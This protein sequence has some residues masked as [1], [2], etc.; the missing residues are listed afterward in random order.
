MSVIVSD[1]R[2]AS[3]D[4]GLATANGFFRAEAYNL[5]MNAQTGSALNTFRTLAVTFANAGNCQ[6]IIF[7]MFAISSAL[8]RIVTVRLQ[9]ATAVDSFNTSTERVNRV[10]HGLANDTPV[11][12]SSTG[13]LP[14]GITAGT[15]YY[16]INQ[17]AN[18][19]QISTTVGGSAVGLS[20]TPT[21]TATAW[22]DRAS[23]VMSTTDIMGAQPT[24]GTS[25][26]NWPMFNGFVPIDFATP[27]AVDTTANK[28]R[29][30]IYQSGGTGGTWYI[31]TS[32][33]TNPFYVTWCDT[34]I[35]SAD[36]DVL[37]VKDKVIFNKSITLVGLTGTG[38]TTQST[39]GLICRNSDF[40]PANVALLEWENPPSS[41]YTFTLKGDFYCFGSHSGFRIGTSGSPI[42]ASTPFT[43][44]LEAPTNGSAVRSTL[45]APGGAMSAS[46]YAAKGSFFAYGE[47]PTLRKTQLTSDALT[48]QAHL[49]VADDVSSW[50]AGDILAVGKQDTASGGSTADLVIQSVA[51][52][53]ITLTANLLTAA[54]LT[55]GSVVNLTR[56]YGGY[57]S[58]P[59]NLLYGEIIP[60]YPSNFVIKGCSL[61]DVRVNTSSRTYYYCIDDDANVSGHVISD[62]A[63]R[64]TNTTLG[65][66][67][68]AI[69]AP[70]QEIEISRNH[71]FRAAIVNAITGYFNS[72]LKT[73]YAT[74]DDNI[75]IGN[76]TSSNFAPSTQ[77]KLTAR[78]NRFE[79]SGRYG[80][81]IGGLDLIFTD[82]VFWG[83][84]AT[85]AS[86][87]STLAVTQTFNPIEVGRNT[88]DKCGTAWQ[89]NAYVSTGC[90]DVDSVFGAEAANIVDIKMLAGS[91]IDYTF[92]SP[93]G[94]LVID[95]TYMPDAVSGSELRFVD[96]ND[97][98]HSDR[99]ITP[100]GTFRRCGYG[101]TDTTVWNGSAFAAADTPGQYAMRMIPD[102]NAAGILSYG[103]TKTTGDISGKLMNVSARVK[104]KNAA[105]YAGTHTNPT[106]RVVYDTT[107][108]IS[109]VAANTTDAQLLQVTFTPQTSAGSIRVYVE[110]GTDAAE[111]DAEFYLGELNIPLPEGVS[112]DTTRLGIWANALPLPSSSTFES[113]DSAWSAPSSA[114][115][116]PGT[117][118]ALLK[119]LLT[120]GQFIGLK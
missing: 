88:F 18:D 31:L 42:P 117:M 6:G 59:S 4:Q 58:A 44:S 96:F 113:P 99:T 79:N 76:Q 105:Y 82:N 109:S 39:A 66:F 72:N 28:W 32:D 112:V 10:A 11:T 19:Y 92:Q 9:E 94:S 23:N 110:G 89:H 13:T 57:F 52:N 47:I 36:N 103:Q 24:S 69:Y 46:T 107:E 65:A 34:Q 25:R 2:N 29:F 35:T 8:D 120:I 12:F 37:I 1:S 22:A 91:I 49:I 61:V 98:T 104:I 118:G 43:I 106:L 16:V 73:G 26:N 53:D 63:C 20:G 84:T 3:Y 86:D 67:V 55:G 45:R 93:S 116:T 30:H 111:A 41:A 95:T 56:G 48:G 33:G 21:G 62:N 83:I 80:A 64:M 100:E 27:Y 87:Y 5:G 71:L 7:N 15:V 77:A 101:L 40:T 90:L 114:F 102:L 119:K 75:C 51:T 115:N 78:R 38:D 74:C 54:R 68:S 14:T 17:T 85:P 108:E 50:Q 70:K 81:A 60:H 97:V